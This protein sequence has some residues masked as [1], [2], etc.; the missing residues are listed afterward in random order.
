MP[1]FISALVI[2]RGDHASF[3]VQ[4]FHTTYFSQFEDL[5]YLAFIF[6]HSPYSIM[7][8]SE[9][10]K[11]KD[12]SSNTY[13]ELKHYKLLRAFYVSLVFCLPLSNSLRNTN[14][15]IIAQDKGTYSNSLAEREHKPMFYNH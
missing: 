2:S 15:F 5:H 6:S 9:F 4:F 14:I 13:W 12:N 10:P 1:V 3:G 7:L 11:I 8:N